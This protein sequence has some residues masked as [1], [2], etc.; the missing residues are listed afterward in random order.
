MKTSLRV[1]VL[2]AGLLTMPA[3]AQED[4]VYESLG[5]IPIGRVFLSPE[6]RARLGERAVA[7]GWH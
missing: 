4:G 6:E 2:F 5:Q 3:V 1:T 7:R